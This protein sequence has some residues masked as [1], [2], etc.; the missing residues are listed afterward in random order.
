MG[1]GG[2][3]SPVVQIREA[4]TGLGL[5]DDAVTSRQVGSLR[6]GALPRRAVELAP[7]IDRDGGATNRL[8]V[9][10]RYV[11]HSAAWS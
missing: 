5:D 2:R 10:T 1:V 9:G 7:A 6:S 3:R 11:V 8:A 4:A